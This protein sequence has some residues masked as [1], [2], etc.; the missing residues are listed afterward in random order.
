M[1]KNSTQ[2]RTIKQPPVNGKNI[3]AHDVQKALNTL[4]KKVYLLRQNDR[5]HSGTKDNSFPDMPRRRAKMSP[6]GVKITARKVKQ[7][8]LEELVSGITKE[9][10]Y[11]E[12]VYQ[13]SQ[14]SQAADSANECRSLHSIAVGNNGRI[15]I[16]KAI[17]S[18]LG[19]NAGGRVELVVQEDMIR[20]IPAADRPRAYVKLLKIAS[21]VF[22]SI[23]N[24]SLWLHEP[25]F[26]L[27]QKRPIDHMR[28]AKGAKEVEN[29]LMKIAHGLVV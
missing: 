24:A 13:V 14:S 26:A 11:P 20:I 23:E 10:N 15:T 5:P 17:R 16:P 7:V 21:E 19:M 3:T 28:T 29:V 6:A 25:Q 4:E 2:L 18:S 27:Y 12:D 8:T 1:K 9:N 22:G